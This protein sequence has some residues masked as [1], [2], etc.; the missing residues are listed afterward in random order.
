MTEPPAIPE[1]CAVGIE[2]HEWNIT[3]DCG[4]LIV[5]S[6]CLTC[7]MNLESDAVTGTLTGRLKYWEEH[8]NVG[9]WDFDE[10]CDCAWGFEFTAVDPTARVAPHPPTRT[11]PLAS[12]SEAS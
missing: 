2:G 7:N 12:A 4:A 1:T 3:F 11:G 9:G 6:G 8:P 10:R 5:T